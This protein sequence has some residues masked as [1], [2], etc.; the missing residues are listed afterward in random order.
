MNATVSA[1][2][3][4]QGTSPT[5]EVH[6]AALAEITV[7][8]VDI[9]HFEFN[10]EFFGQLLKEHLDALKEILD[11]TV[12]ARPAPDQPFNVVAMH[13]VDPKWSEFANDTVSVHIG[14]GISTHDQRRGFMEQLREA[15]VPR[16]IELLVPQWDKTDAEK[17]AEV[18]HSAAAC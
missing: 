15:L 1:A 2:S 4:T 7:K 8:Y 12:T 11:Q 16:G 18:D 14:V 3:V 6:S 17:D 9:K 5:S 13:L 10:A